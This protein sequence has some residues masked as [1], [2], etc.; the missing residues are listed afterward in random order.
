MQDWTYLGECIKRDRKQKQWLQ[1]DLAEA[2]GLT[3]RTIGTYEAGRPPASA[4]DIPSGYYAVGVALGW[5]ADGVERALNGGNPK[6]ETRVATGTAV[7]VSASGAS[8]LDLYPAVGRFARAAVAA[9]GD[10]VLRDL[11]EEAADRLLQ[12]VPQ[13]P[14]QSAPQPGYGL[15]AYRPHAWAE[16]DTG[17]PDDDAARIEQALEEH[18]RH[19]RQEP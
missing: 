10:P 9:G 19:G 16:G 7:E 13:R 3:K 14:A 6:G 11:L 15:A 5:L 18:A 1:A 2:A 12:S 8:V 4:P 17:V